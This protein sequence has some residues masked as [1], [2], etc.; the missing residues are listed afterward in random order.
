MK[1]IWCDLSCWFICPVFNLNF[2]NDHDNISFNLIILSI[3]I[4]FFNA[5]FYRQSQGYTNKKT[6]KICP[7]WQI[8]PYYHGHYRCLCYSSK[9]RTDEP[10]WQIT[11]YYRGHYGC[12]CYSS[13]HRT[14][15]PT[16][17]ITP[18]YHGHFGYMVW[19]VM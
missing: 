1:L 8:T 6:N 3:F 7:T 19:F 4:M 13:K 9:H 10:T 16:W 12:L 11:P 14:D 5:K 18:Y 15:E 2:Y 17:Q